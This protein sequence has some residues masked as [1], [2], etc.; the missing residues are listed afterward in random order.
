[1]CKFHVTIEL[2]YALG[3]FTLPFKAF[4]IFHA[5]HDIITLPVD[6]P[7]TIP[8]RSFSETLVQFAVVHGSFAGVLVGH[9]YVWI[10]RWTSSFNPFAV[11]FVC[12]NEG[13]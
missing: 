5:L 10:D 2:T 11:S 1:M 13:I 12:E 9:A 4:V 6:V 7:V 8:T 3:Q